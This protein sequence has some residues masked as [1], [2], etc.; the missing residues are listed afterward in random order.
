MLFSV[1]T[2][3]TKIRI[4]SVQADGQDNSCASDFFLRKETEVR[5]AQRDLDNR[6]NMQTRN[7][8][9]HSMQNCRL[10]CAVHSSYSCWACT[11]LQH[12]QCWGSNRCK[13]QQLLQ[14][15]GHSL[16]LRIIPRWAAAEMSLALWNTLTGQ[17]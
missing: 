8:R 16:C 10:F 3:V 14:L 12:A 17:Y 4:L 6:Q 11:V 13:C 7:V 15:S 2:S 1:G 5:W 9:Q